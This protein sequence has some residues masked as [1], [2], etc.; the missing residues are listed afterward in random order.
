MTKVLGRVHH[1]ESEGVDRA[2]SPAISEGSVGLGGPQDPVLDH[3]AMPEVSPHT[4]AGDQ[5]LPS[6]RPLTMARKP[7]VNLNPP[8]RRRMSPVKMRM[9][10]FVRM[11]LRS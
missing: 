8:M 2:P 7:A 6:L 3:A 10:R 5:A 9:W 11:M 4:T 1:Q